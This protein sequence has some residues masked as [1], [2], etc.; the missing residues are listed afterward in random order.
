MGGGGDRVIINASNAE[1]Q[2]DEADLVLSFHE[3][4]CFLRPLQYFD[5]GENISAVPDLL[6]LQQNNFKN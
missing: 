3:R 1:K 5:E 6:I 2:K 4:I